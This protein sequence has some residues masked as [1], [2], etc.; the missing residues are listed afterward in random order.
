MAKRI[1]LYTPLPYLED[2]HKKA[3]TKSENVNIKADVLRMI[4]MDHSNMVAE[5]GSRVEEPKVAKHR[6]KL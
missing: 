4:L 5:L 1:K 6:E 2:L 3:D